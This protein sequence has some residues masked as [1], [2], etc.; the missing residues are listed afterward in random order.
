[1]ASNLSIETS[2]RL[3]NLG[4]SMAVQKLGCA[5]ISFA[6]MASY[7]F[8]KREENKHLEIEHLAAVEQFLLH[9]PTYTLLDCSHSPLLSLELLQSLYQHMRHFSPV[10]AY[11]P[12]AST[13]SSLISFLSSMEEVRFLILNPV[14]LHALIQIQKPMHMYK[15]AQ[16]QIV[17]LD[18]ITLEV[19]ALSLL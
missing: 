11:I 2:I 7:L 8:E 16:N 3:A 17:P 1:M 9:S 6:Q 15:I 5:S 13:D 10:I 12:T 14:L 18:S 19:D 4:A